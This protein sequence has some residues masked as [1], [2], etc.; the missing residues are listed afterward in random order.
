MNNISVMSDLLVGQSARISHLASGEHIRRRLQDI[1]IIPG[2]L[3]KCIMKSPFGDPAAYSVRG[4]IIAI[5][6]SDAEKILVSP[7][8]GASSDGT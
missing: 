6:R 7:A 8:G 4:A 5:R 2:T 1:G 3:I